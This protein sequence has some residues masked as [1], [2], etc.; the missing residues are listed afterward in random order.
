M[1]GSCP[2]FAFLDIF[3][4]QDA[5]RHRAFAHDAGGDVAVSDGLNLERVQAAEGRDLLEAERRVVDQPDGGGF[6]H[7]RFGHG[8]LV[9]YCGVKMINGGFLPHAPDNNGE[10]PKVKEK[11]HKNWLNLDKKAFF[12]MLRSC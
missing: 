3:V 2:G 1:L 9:K 8:I 7:Q 11:R 10:S 4:G 12:M 6:W 5:L